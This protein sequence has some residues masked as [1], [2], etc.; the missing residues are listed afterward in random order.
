[1]PQA[2]FCVQC[3]LKAMLANEQP[4]FFNES[5]EDHVQRVHPNLE[6]TKR[7]RVEMERALAERIA[8]SRNARNN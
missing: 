1:M 8:R 2:L 7:E 3:A 6:A 5:M 4:T